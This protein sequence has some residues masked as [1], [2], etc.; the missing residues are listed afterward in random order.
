MGKIAIEI[1][2]PQH[3]PGKSTAE[4]LPAGDVE[5]PA[6]LPV[7]FKIL[8]WSAYGL[9]GFALWQVARLFLKM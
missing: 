7:F 1:R 4:P 3:L 5:R 9:C 8:L 6:G 2:K